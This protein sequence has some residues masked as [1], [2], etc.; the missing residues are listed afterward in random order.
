MCFTLQERY[1][2]TSI[3]LILF[4]FNVLKTYL[5]SSLV[6][7]KFTIKDKVDDAIKFMYILE[8]LIHL[9]QQVISSEK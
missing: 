8:R 3:M 2:L 1:F 5:S 4:L 7:E 9:S 6:K